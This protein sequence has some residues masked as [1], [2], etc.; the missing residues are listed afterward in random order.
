L[1]NPAYA[2]L[3]A[4]NP[5]V[6]VAGG[7]PGPRA[8]SGGMSPIA[9]LRGM[10]AA[11]AKLDAYAHNPYPERPKI[12][13]PT[14]GGCAR[15][16]TVTMA[17]LGKLLTETQRAWP[18]KRIWLTEYGYQTNPPDR[19]LGVSYGLQARYIG[20]AALRV[21]RAPRVDML[22]QFIIRDDANQAG[23]QSGF[24]TTAGKVK[25]SYDAW[26]FPLAQASRSGTRTVLWGEIRPR[27]GAQTYRLQVYRGGRWQ[28]VGGTT[29][30]NGRGIFQRTLTA[31][32]GTKVRLY[33]LR[34]RAASPALVIR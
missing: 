3:H 11:N 30:T 12:E 17:T 1:L 5:S 23:W 31:P 9:F 7:V 15:C 13:S 16:A 24:F 21:Y 18:G 14:S 27:S 4:A 10:K 25:P 2:A 32:K 22:I 33:S 8:G 26:R 28:A 6:R 29:R 20:E 19:D 34:D